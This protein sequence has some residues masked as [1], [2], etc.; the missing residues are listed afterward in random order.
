MKTLGII[1]IMLGLSI[2][3]YVGIISIHKENKEH[4]IKSTHQK[5]PFIANPVL[6][7]LTTGFGVV[8]MLAKRKY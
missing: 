1:L 4:S 6:G 7:I 8:L 5:D 3:T 2:T